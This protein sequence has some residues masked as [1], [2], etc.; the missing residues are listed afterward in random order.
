[1]LGGANH[2]IAPVAGG[3][4]QAQQVFRRNFDP[5]Q[6]FAQRF[7]ATLAF[8]GEDHRAG[9]RFEEA[10]QIIQRR[11]VLRLDGEVRQRLV[12]QVGIRCFFGQ[13]LG[14]QLNARP[15]FQFA[16]QL[17]AAQPQ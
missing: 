4:L 2:Q 14:F 11:F 17:I 7:P 5:R 8:N 10:A 13:A 6:H 3:F 1:M 12:A 9:K 16:E 15:L